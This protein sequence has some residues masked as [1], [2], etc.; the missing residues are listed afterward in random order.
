MHISIEEVR[1]FF[2]YQDGQLF[3]KKSPNP[4]ANRAKVGQLAGTLRKGENRWQ[5]GYEGRAYF[6]SRLIFAWHHGKWPEPTCDHIN[7][8]SLDDR[9]ENL[10]EATHSEQIYNQKKRIVINKPK[11]NEMHPFGKMYT[12]PIC[13]HIGKGGGM[14]RWH[15]D[16][17]KDM[18]K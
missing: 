14:K 1:E 16:N 17:C 5:I 3:W 13:K 7:R 8:N 6:R 2:D 10:R 4:Y 12:C 15:F 9:I 11:R 18:K